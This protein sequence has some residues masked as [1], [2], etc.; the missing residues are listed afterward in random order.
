M[1]LLKKQHKMLNKQ[2]ILVQAAV[3]ISLYL[4]IRYVLKEIVWK[5]VNHNLLEGF[6]KSQADSFVLFHM[7]KCPHCVDMMGEWNSFASSYDG[8]VKIM[9]IEKSEMGNSEYKDVKV[10]GFPT[11]KVFDANKKEIAEY[12][13]NR[14]ASD[15]KAFLE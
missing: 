5:N 10:S 9:K 12:S 11:M 6:D 8:P 13:G 3:Y 15:F 1:R 2:N 14:K 4:V 7:N